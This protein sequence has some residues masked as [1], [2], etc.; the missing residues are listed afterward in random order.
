MDLINKDLVVILSYS[1]DVL[2]P[3]FFQSS[4][5]GLKPVYREITNE[6][7]AMDGEL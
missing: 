5:Q 6:E 1:E 2:D 3:S 4:S 7:I